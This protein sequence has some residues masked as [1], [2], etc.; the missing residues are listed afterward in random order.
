MRQFGPIG[1]ID[2]WAMP[3]MQTILRSKFPDTLL[4]PAL[5]ESAAGLWL[6]WS[7]QP[8]TIRLLARQSFHS[9]EAHLWG[10]PRP[11][12]ETCRARLA[13]RIA[14]DLPDATVALSDADT[15]TVTSPWREV[16]QPA[17]LARVAALF[18]EEFEGMRLMLR[19]TAGQWRGT[20]DDRPLAEGTL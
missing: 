20:P 1:F 14:Q 10:V 17:A 2:A 16:T 18:G 4:E 3:A 9:V 8:Q 11:D 5:L 19:F 7:L 15:L 6:E 13:R 12:I